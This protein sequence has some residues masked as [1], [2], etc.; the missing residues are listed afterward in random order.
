MNTLFC[1]GVTGFEPATSRPQTCTLTGLS[2][3]PNFASAKVH[4][5]FEFANKIFPFISNPWFPDRSPGCPESLPWWPT[6]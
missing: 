4:L 5:I 2:Y 3:T 6:D 1:V